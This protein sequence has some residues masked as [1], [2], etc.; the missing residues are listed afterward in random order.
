[1]ERASKPDIFSN[2]PLT[3]IL[4]ILGSLDTASFR[5]RSLSLLRGSTYYPILIYNLQFTTWKVIT[6]KVVIVFHV[7]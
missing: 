4:W 7:A 2:W 6:I 1:M 3:N 5:F